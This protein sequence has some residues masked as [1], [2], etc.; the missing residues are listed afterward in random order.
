[1]GRLIRGDLLVVFV[2]VVGLLAL[3]IPGLIAMAYLA[4]VGPVIEIENLPAVA[5][6]R[7]SVHLVR[8]RVWAVVLLA[9]LPTIA[10]SQ[11]PTT[12]PHPASTGSVLVFVGLRAGEALAEAA[13]ALLAVELCYW[14]IELDAASPAASLSARK[15]RRPE[16]APPDSGGR[17]SRLV[18]DMAADPVPL[19]AHGQ[20]G[21]REPAA[22]RL[23]RHLVRVADRVHVDQLRCH[24][25]TEV[26]PQQAGE[27][28]PARVC[29][30]HGNAEDEARIGPTQAE[31]PETAVAG[32]PRRRG[33][34]RS[35]RPR[36]ALQQ[37][38]SHLRGVHPDQHHRD[39]QPGVG[40]VQRRGDPLI[41]PVT[42]LPGHLK[43][44]RQPGGAGGT[45]P[46]PAAERG[47]CAGQGEH[48]PGEGGTGRG[49]QGVGQRGFGQPGRLVRRER[50]R[51]PG[52]DASRD[53]RLGD[54]HQLRREPPH[55]AST[56]RM[57]R[58]VRTV[59]PTVPV[60]LDR[61]DRGR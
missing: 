57:S 49:L 55:D 33:P 1:M 47:G 32:R 38:G 15:Q 14:L 60:T 18:Q 4:V 37:P 12:F 30:R 44:R 48:A 42:A 8:Q 5:A 24:P 59:P 9:T 7:R 51:E 61:P 22:R 46:T 39:R 27:L 13:L 3:V 35:K 40:V 28:P 52:L 11:I 26:R 10:A 2:V 17:V 21:G 25:D 16:A 53:R 56:R 45:S 29:L 34:P 50:R 36:H 54:D 41:E 58:T 23:A 19:I 31:H 43:P 20:H 6:L